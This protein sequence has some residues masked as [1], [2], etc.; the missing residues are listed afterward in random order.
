VSRRARDLA[1]DLAWTQWSALTSSIS[2]TTTSPQ[3]AIDPEALVLL[4]CVADR[5]ERR[6]LD[7][8]RAWFTEGIALVSVQRTRSLA[9]RLPARYQ[10]A[11]GTIAALAELAGDH[12]WKRYA[13]REGVAKAA[14]SRPKQSGP[15]RLSA[16]AALMLRLRAGFGAGTKADVLAVLLGTR[17]PVTLAAIAAALRYAPQPLRRA[18]D[19]MVAAGFVERIESSPARYRGSTAQWRNVLNP[20]GHDSASGSKLHIRWMPWADIVEFLAYTLD[21]ADGTTSSTSSDYIA[22]SRARDLV[23]AHA[24]PAMVEMLSLR[25]P[26]SSEAWDLSSFEALVRVLDT[27]VRERW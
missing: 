9:A 4:S 23:E 2:R 10:E 17:E 5:S 7:V 25:S 13:T 14:A 19:D 1:V 27:K 8:M 18:I 12:R 22:A 20:G 26:A 11:L 15:L 16:P 6:L 21:W 3:A 24:T